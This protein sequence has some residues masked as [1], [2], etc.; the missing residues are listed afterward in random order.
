[1]CGLRE[2]SG[3]HRGVNEAFARFAMLR[4]RRLVYFWTEV[5]RSSNLALEDETGVVFGT[6]VNQSQTCPA[7]H[8]RKRSLPPSSMMILRLTLHETYT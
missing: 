8:S 1:M 2:V 5:K 3:T 4:A 7:Q 6:Y